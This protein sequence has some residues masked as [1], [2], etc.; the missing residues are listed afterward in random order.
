[1]RPGGEGWRRAGP[2]GCP[3]PL[4]TARTPAQARPS[5]LQLRSEAQKAPPDW[6][7]ARGDGFLRKGGA[8]TPFF[9]FF[10]GPRSAEVAH[11]FAGIYRVR[12][13]KL[14]NSVKVAWSTPS[15]TLCSWGGFGP[16]GA[17][18]FAPVHPLLCF[19]LPAMIRLLP[20]QHP[21][22]TEYFLVCSEYLP[23]FAEYF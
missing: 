23:A 20:F 6:L 10:P 19:T 2:R 9:F 4:S 8:A 13:F 18:C 15:L 12:F 11:S 3:A 1:M 16:P 14:L 5:P 21:A 17:F 22:F 7:R